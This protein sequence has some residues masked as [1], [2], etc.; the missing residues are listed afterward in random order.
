MPEP[1]NST[2][3]RLISPTAAAAFSGR[4]VLLDVRSPLEF[5]TEHIQDSINIPLDQLEARLDAVPRHGELVVICRTGKRA[6]RGAHALLAGGFQPKVLAGGLIAWRKAGLPIKEGK[7]ML[8]IERQIQLIV[9]IAV[10]AGVL[11][12]AFVNAWFLVIAGF[13][14]AGLT[15]AGLTGTCALGLLLMKAPW[16]RLP[17]LQRTPDAGSENAKPNGGC[18]G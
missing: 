1:S 12:G 9:G 11:L 10:L 8:A 13:F 14:G 7:K 4:S 5:E 6:E 15:F 2:A 18:C 16:N 17:Q 3:C